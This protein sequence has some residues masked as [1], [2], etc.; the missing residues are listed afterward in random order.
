[1]PESLLTQLCFDYE[2]GSYNS[3]LPIFNVRSVFQNVITFW[4]VIQ[5]LIV[6]PWIGLS[7]RKPNLNLRVFA[8]FS[9][10]LF[11]LFLQ[12]LRYYKTIGSS[13]LKQLQTVAII[14]AKIV[15]CFA[16]SI[17]GEHL[18]GEFRKAGD[19]HE[20]NKNAEILETKHHLK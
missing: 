15:L 3:R 16:T 20:T 17:I 9:V 19:N 8:L 4:T 14:C 5:K 6:L 11:L 12:R 13:Y 1:M 18:V 2:N 10:F 7:K